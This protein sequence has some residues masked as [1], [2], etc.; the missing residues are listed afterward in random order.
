MRQRPGVGQVIDRHD[1][2]AIAF[3]SAPHERTANTPEAIDSHLDW[4]RALLF[5]QSP[6]SLAG[7]PCGQPLSYV[8]SLADARGI[9]QRPSA[10]SARPL[11]LGGAA[12]ERV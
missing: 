5:P 2:Q 4:H 1:L 8:A 12:E 7:Q 3:Q 6:A 10:P 9:P 11:V